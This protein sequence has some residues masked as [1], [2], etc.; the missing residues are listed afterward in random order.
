MSKKSPLLKIDKE[1]AIFEAALKIITN[2]G[3]HKARMSDIAKQ[4]GISYGLIYH[5]FKNKESLFDAIIARWWEGLFQCFDEILGTDMPVE[6]KLRKIV[7]YHLCT[8]QDSPELV[9]IFTTEISRSTANLTKD[10]LDRFKK[11]ISM[12][13]SV[14]AEGQQVGLLRSDY[15]P[16]YLTNIFLGALD[17]FISTMVLAG[18]KI[19][20]DKQRNTIAESL[21]EVF[22]NGAKSR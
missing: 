20:G 19:K 2:K 1:E 16:R 12:T 6:T 9:N 3:F 14:I 21:L 7:D 5:Y 8:Y 18:Q 22:L 13:E 4:A 17:S 10:R 15:K 11:F